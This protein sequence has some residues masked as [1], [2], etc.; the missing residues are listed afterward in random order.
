MHAYLVSGIRLSFPE[1]TL[2]TAVE[3]PEYADGTDQDIGRG[4]EVEYPGIETITNGNTPITG[5]FDVGSTHGTL[6]FDLLYS[7]QTEE[8]GQHKNQPE[9][10]FP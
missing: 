10:F 5:G 4:Q 1:L 7:G 3:V 6:S 2:L 8:E 9:K